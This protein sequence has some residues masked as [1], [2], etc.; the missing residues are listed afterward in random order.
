MLSTGPAPNVDEIV[1]G[2]FRISS[3]VAP[4]GLTVN[5]FLV[6]A[7]EPALVHL[8]TR[9][10]FAAARDAMG[11]ILDVATLRWLTFG[12]VEADECG[13][14]N[15]WLAAAPRARVAFNPLGCVMQLDDLAD[16]RPRQLGD[17]D[18][19]DLGGRR[20][21]VLVTPHAPHNLEAQVLYEEVTSTLFCGDLCTTAGDGPP[22]TSDAEHLVAEVFAAETALPSAAPGP[23]V[24]DA[25]RRL[26]RLR[27]RLVAPMHG[28]AFRGD[29][30]A[31]LTAVA[32]GWQQMAHHSSQPREEP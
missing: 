23:A 10:G 28:A 16:R 27:P 9:G 29:G 18:V 15:D 25:L 6:L 5:Q 31:V 22:V 2:V 19:L 30:E 14:L 8:G 21:Q 26:A 24:P 20:L 3:F 13:S 12:H 11:Q 32:D 1:D 17:S 7:D 4:L